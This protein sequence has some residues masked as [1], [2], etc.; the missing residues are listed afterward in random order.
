MSSDSLINF[1]TE[2]YLSQYPDLQSSIKNLSDIDKQLWLLA[3]YLKHGTKEHRKYRLKYDCHRKPSA[4]TTIDPEVKQHID[5]FHQKCRSIK[6][7]YR[8]HN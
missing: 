7:R 3:H 8:T 2:Y 1:D 6:D 4:K 5:Q